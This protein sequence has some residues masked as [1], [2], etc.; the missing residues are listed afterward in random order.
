MQ[1]RGAHE[2]GKKRARAPKI[3]V[4]PSLTDD[5]YGVAPKSSSGTLRFYSLSSSCP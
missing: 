2:S 5:L 4:S 1:S 3:E